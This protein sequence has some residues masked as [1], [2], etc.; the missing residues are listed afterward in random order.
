MAPTL[1]MVLGCYYLTEIQ[2]GD[3]GEGSRFYDYDEASIAFADGHIGLRAKIYVKDIPGYE[4]DEAWVETTLGRLIF[5]ENLPT[6]IGFK[7]YVFNSRAIKELT[8]ELYQKLSNDE[9]AEALDKIKQLGFKYATTSGITIA[10]NDIQIS[11]KKSQILQEADGLVE[12]Y[13]DQ[14]LSGLMSEDE[15]YNSAVEAWTRASD[16]TEQL[17]KDEIEI[18][19]YGGIGCDGAFRRQR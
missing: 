18:G 19:N 7:N 4:T 16:Q 13:E 5:K 11:G 1:D 6:E 14:Y 9:T 10:I 8:T 17:V 12:S 3:K 15:R 2:R